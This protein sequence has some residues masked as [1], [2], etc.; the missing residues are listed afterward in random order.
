MFNYREFSPVLV[1][2][3]FL[4]LREDSRTKMHLTD[5]KITLEQSLLAV[6]ADNLSFLSWTKTRDAENGMNRPKSILNR[7][8]NGPVE[9]EIIEF[10]SLDEFENEKQRILGGR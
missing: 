7:L 1:G 2:T 6:I 10:N 4:G 3:L 9:T 8:L 5:Q